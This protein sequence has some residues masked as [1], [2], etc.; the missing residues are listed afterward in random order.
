MFILVL[1]IAVSGCVTSP[2][3][4]K[5]SN[6]GSDVTFLKKHTDVIVLEAPGSEGKVAFIP[7]LQARVMTSSAKGD[8][9]TSFGWINY[10]LTKNQER[11]THINVFGGEDRFWIGPEGGKYSIFFKKGESQTFANWETPAPID[12]GAWDL[13]EKNKCSAWCKK[14][15]NLVN[16]E[17]TKFDLSVKRGVR[18]YGKKDI[19]K[20]LKVKIAKDVSFVG[21]ETENYITNKGKQKWTKKKGLLSIWILGMFN[22]SEKTVIV[23]PFKKGP[24]SK[25]GRIVKD[26]YFGKVPGDR[27]KV[28]KKKGV[29]YFKGDGKMRTKIGVALKRAADICGSYSP[30][31][32]T[33]TI[34]QYT[35][36][37]DKDYVNSMWTDDDDSV[38]P[39]GGDVVN[40]YND[41]PNDA[42]EIFGPYYE[43]E[44]SSPA[45]ELAKGEHVKHVH[46]TF[47]FQGDEAKL[48]S[49]SEKLLGVK[50]NEIKT[51][52]EK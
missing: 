41:G 25:L 19:E 39:Y 1:T 32:R 40:S 10:D 47:H 45:L 26:D 23:L 50:L 12:W 30:E 8:S 38:D 49:L 9:G 44:S 16:H 11:Q 37:G 34:V 22:H 5:S 21:Y 4:S 24:K 35:I 31:T 15:F 27:L 43:L 2:L 3:K 13:V 6:F 42:G 48:N 33:L 17:G 52:F 7:S 18:I 29:I 36:P 51:A 28:D 20:Q 46:R 14:D